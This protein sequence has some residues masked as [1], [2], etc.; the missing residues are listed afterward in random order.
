M[1]FILH[2]I[3]DYGTQVIGLILAWFV[4]KAIIEVRS[5]RETQMKAELAFDEVSARVPSFKEKYDF[6]L[7]HL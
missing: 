6:W 5:L 3:K 1:E 2:A 4:R 7:A